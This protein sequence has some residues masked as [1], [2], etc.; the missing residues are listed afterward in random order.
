[1]RVKVE[2]TKDLLN[3]PYTTSVIK[4]VTSC[5][6]R[7]NSEPANSS[8]DKIGEAVSQISNRV[9]MNEGITLEDAALVVRCV[10]AVWASRVEGD[11][12]RETKAREEET[13][14][15]RRRGPASLD[16]LPQ[17]MAFRSCLQ[18]GAE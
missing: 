1:V 13:F 8:K 14:A 7:T 4:L 16:D 15:P 17:L 18:I 11:D 10:P 5:L 2:S 9:G 12:V 6:T 3:I